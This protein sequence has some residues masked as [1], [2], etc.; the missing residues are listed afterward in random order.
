MA[1]PKPNIYLT[2]TGSLRVDVDKLNNYGLSWTLQKLHGVTPISMTMNRSDKKLLTKV[3]DNYAKYINTGYADYIVEDKAAEAIEQALEEAD[4]GQAP[5]LPLTPY[6]KLGAIDNLELLTAKFSAGV[7]GDKN[8]VHTIEGKQYSF[9]V[10]ERTYS[11]EFPREKMHTTKDGTEVRVHDCTLEG[12]D[13]MFEFKDEN[14]VWWSFREHPEFNYEL[15]ERKVWEYFHEPEIPTLKETQ[16]DKYESNQEMLDYMEDIGPPEFKF[17]PGQREYLARFAILDQGQSAIETGGGKTLIAIALYYLKHA[18]RACFIVPKGTSVGE[19]GKTNIDDTPQWF[20]EVAKFAPDVPVHKLFSIDDYKAKLRDNGKLPP[21]IYIS[22]S[23]ALFNNGGA[24]ECIPKTKVWK[25]DAGEK[26]FCQKFK[27]EYN[28]ELGINYTK[29]I[30]VE[31][32]GIFCMARPSLSTI[33]KHQFDMVMV[34]E[35]HCMCN[36]NTNITQGLLRMQPRYRYA[37]TATPIPNMCYN[38]FSIMG[39]LRNQ[40]WRIDRRRTTAWPYAIQEITKFKRLH[41]SKEKDL[42][43]INEAHKRGDNPPNPIDSPVISQIPRLL[44]TLRMTVGFMSKEDINPNMVKCNVRKIAV[45]LGKQQHALYAHYLERANIPIEN[46]LARALAQHS[47][48]R[49]VCADPA[50]CNF[51]KV[52]HLKVKSNYNAKTIAVLQL[53]AEDLK[54]GEQ[55]VFVAARNGQIHE[56]E[57]RLSQANIPYSKITGEPGCKQSHEANMFKSGETK[58]MLMNIYMAQAY[59][60]ENSSHVI[61]G[62]LEWSYGKFAQACGRVYRLTSPKDCTVSVVL[63]ENTIEELLYEKVAT[64]E[65]AATICLKGEKPSNKAKTVDPSELLAQH[66]Q[67]FSSMNHSVMEEDEQEHQWPELLAELKGEVVKC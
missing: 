23:H 5:I 40:D 42:T 37:M 12:T 59:S 14:E 13:T 33:T 18:K 45:P 9:G 4:E 15:D 46:P 38:I 20:K 22:Y 62:S 56:L 61:I 19:E 49:G 26:K 67:D 10:R 25:G 29:G 17:Y 27:L 7:D 31:K 65:D 2:L 64:K 57:R 6:E 39:W 43:A 63:H 58:V 28:S 41:V 52:E 48:L 8:Q 44:Y 11:R 21:G 47:Y 54:K 35:A 66:F 50:T 55:T 30:G 1:K 24:F 34:D 16:P 36:L 3:L 32:N 53:I 51:N 60:F